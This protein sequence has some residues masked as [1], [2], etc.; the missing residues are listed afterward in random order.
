MP[1]P[2]PAISTAPAPGRRRRSRF[3]CL[4][5]LAVSAFVGACG[6]EEEPT[7]KQPTSASQEPDADKPPATDEPSLMGTP[8][9]EESIDEAVDRIDD[10]LRSGDCEKINELNP[11]GRPQLATEQ[12]CEVLKRLEGLEVAKAAEYGKLGAVINYE[13]GLGTVSAVLVRDSDGLLHLAFIDPFIAEPSVGSEL[14]KEFERVA[15]QGTK[16]LAERECEPFLELAFRRFGL[17]AGEDGEVC[18]RVETNVVAALLEAGGEAKPVDL[19]G[20]S[21]YAFFG[22]DTP[23]SYITVIAARQTEEGLSEELPKEIAEL[24]EGAGEYGIADALRTNPRQPIEAPA[25]AAEEAPPGSAH[26]PD[27]AG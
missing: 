8:P 6:S 9:V 3:A 19:E 15:E 13:R 2:E 22:V 21:A 7:A 14:A 12:R 20:N 4:A 17:G 11:L 25:G 16:A 1:P 10:V 23:S 24:P 26:T 5:L 18:D 27:S